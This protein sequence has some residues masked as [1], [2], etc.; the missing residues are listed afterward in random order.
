MQQML[1]LQVLRKAQP[2]RLGIF[3][4]RYLGDGK[5]YPDMTQSYHLF[6]WYLKKPQIFRLSKLK[7]IQILVGCIKIPLLKGQQMFIGLPMSATWKWAKPST[8]RCLVCSACE[9]IAKASLRTITRTSS[10]VTMGRQLSFRLGLSLWY[11]V[12]ILAK[13][14]GDCVWNPK[15]IQVLVDDFLFPFLF[16]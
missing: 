7:L 14:R 13:K 8:Y 15:M 1:K 5:G 4:G 11:V 10:F 2:C 3:R 6:F 12:V 9:S 16:F